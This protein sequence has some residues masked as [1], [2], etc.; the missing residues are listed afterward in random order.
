MLLGPR[1]LLGNRVVAMANQ[2]HM[3]VEIMEAQKPEISED[4]FILQR[5]ECSTFKERKGKMSLCGSQEEEMGRGDPTLFWFLG[6]LPVLSA[7]ESYKCLLTLFF[8]Q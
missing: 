8:S 4:Q 2:S 1:M 6:S 5:E 7:V 3:A